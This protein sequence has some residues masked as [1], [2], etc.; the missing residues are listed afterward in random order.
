MMPHSS[1]TSQAPSKPSIFLYPLIL[2]IIETAA[3]AARRQQQ[4]SDFE[5]HFFEANRFD[6]LSDRSKFDLGS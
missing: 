5:L 6:D 1:R 3:V 2:V 4:L